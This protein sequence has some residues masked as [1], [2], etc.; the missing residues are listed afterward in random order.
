MAIKFMRKNNRDMVEFSNVR[1]VHRNLRGVKTEYNRVGNRGFSI[2][3]SEDEAE[4]LIDRGYNVRV[5]PSQSNPD[6]KFCFL[7][8][9]VN[10]NNIPPRI[11]RVTEDTMMLLSEA[12]VGIIDTSDIVNVNL[13]VNARYWDINGKQGIKPYVNTMYVEVEEDSFAGK[14]ADRE[15]IS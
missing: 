5:R 3:L 9:A 11:Y 14:Y 15:I 6:D 4:E 12:N 10:Y 13:T 7:P 8:I 1:I 2:V